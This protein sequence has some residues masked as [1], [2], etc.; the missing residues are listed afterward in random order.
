MAAANF[1]AEEFSKDI[2]S[3]EFNKYV[4]YARLIGMSG[5]NRCA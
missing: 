4:N 1:F 3:F 2:D 5:Q